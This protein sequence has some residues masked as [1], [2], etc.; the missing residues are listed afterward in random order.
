MNLWWRSS[1]ENAFCMNMKLI[2]FLK[3]LCCSF[4]KSFKPIWILALSSL[5]FFL[6]SLSE[7]LVVIDLLSRPWRLVIFFYMLTLARFEVLLFDNEACSPDNPA[8]TLPFLSSTSSRISTDFKESSEEYSKDMFFS[9]F[10]L[11]L[12]L[13]PSSFLGSSLP[14]ILSNLPRLIASASC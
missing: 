5:F 14:P 4:F 12:S 7:M 11:E 2:W 6:S 3:H 1:T 9:S 13:W 8:S 10:S